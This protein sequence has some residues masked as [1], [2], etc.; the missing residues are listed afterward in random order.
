M[1]PSGPTT[2]APTAEEKSLL[3]SDTIRLS[4]QGK[5]C[6][7]YT[8]FEAVM[9]SGEVF[10]AHDGT[11]MHGSSGSH[12]EGAQTEGASYTVKYRVVKADGS[13]SFVLASIAV[14]L[15]LSVDS[16]DVVGVQKAQVTSTS[17]LELVDA[18][19]ST[20]DCQPVQPQPVTPPRR[21][22]G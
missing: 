18:L 1:A 10:V 12:I 20:E 16:A 5:S 8:T 9:L 11:H 15:P 2:R 21:L 19:T 3:E 13:E 14:D 4:V 22:G 6:D 7:E 17:A